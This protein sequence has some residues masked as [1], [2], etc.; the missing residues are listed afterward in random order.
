MTI[1]KPIKATRV[2]KIQKE[3]KHKTFK[4]IYTK[5]Q[6][7]MIKAK[8]LKKTLPGSQ[9]RGKSLNKTKNHQ[10]LPQQNPKLVDHLIRRD[11]KIDRNRY[12]TLFCIVNYI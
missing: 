3:L 4:Q 1:N 9:K 8:R 11:E 10:K 5:L 12:F 6:K 2:K 7:E